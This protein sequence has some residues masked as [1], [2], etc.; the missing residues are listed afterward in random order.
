MTNTAQTDKGQLGEDFVNKIAFNSFLKYWCY[1]GPLDIVG[2]NKEF[3]DL[4]IVFDSICIIISVK[5]Y[6]FKDNYERYFKNTIERTTK[7]IIGA[8]RKLFREKTV[9][10][11][12]PDRSP[13]EFNKGNIKKVFRI[14]VNL[15]PSIKYYRTSFKVNGKNF[16]V[17]DAPAWQASLSELNTLPDFINYIENRCSLFNEHPAFIL[18][19]EENDFFENDRNSLWREIEEIAKD[20]RKDGKVTLVSGNELDLIATYIKNGFKFPPELNHNKV[21]FL[22]MKIDGEWTKYQESKLSVIKNNFEKESYFIDQLVRELLIDKENGEKLSKML[23]KLNRIERSAFA[24]NYL[25]F[26]NELKNSA[27]K[28]EFSRTNTVFKGMNMVFVFFVNNLLPEKL[29]Y[30]VEL[31]LIHHSYLQDFECGEIGLIGVSKSFD[32]FMFGYLSDKD[33]KGNVDTRQ[34]E[35]TFEEHGWKINIRP[36]ST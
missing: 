4:L 16:C 32:S 13:E 36:S 18:P 30:F 12:H 7:Q 28:I 8:E 25:K 20:K 14:I 1:P 29:K 11:Q 5:N 33:K 2:D 23:F 3:C 19:R 22:T 24:Q 21:N 9:L 31:S 17:M 26:H 10:L 35:K 27:E 34:L 6:S 15:N